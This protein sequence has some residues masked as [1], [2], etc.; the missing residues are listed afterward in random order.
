MYLHYY[1]YAY[2]RKSD[3]TPY[4][5]GKGKGNR[6][7]AK[8]PGISVPNDNSK[9][10]ILES[11]LT[12]IGACAIERRLIRW[13]GRKDINTGILLNKTNGGDGIA[14]YQHT[15][16]YKQKNREKYK[17]KQVAMPGLDARRKAGL[18]QRG[19]PKPSVS[20]ALKGRKLSE[21]EIESRRGRIPWN[22]GKTGLQKQNEKLFRCP[23]CGKEARA[24]LLARWH[25]SNCKLLTLPLI[26]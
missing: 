19:I 6:A 2:L 11:N 20:A 4:Y 7:W 5:I 16:E 17:G 13:W 8:H 26:K 18:K 25:G 12:D 24:S 3:L 23:H 15:E 9:I 1:V 21:S 22:K 14:G 10:I